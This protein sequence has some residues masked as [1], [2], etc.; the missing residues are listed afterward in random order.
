MRMRVW[1]YFYIEETQIFSK[2]SGGKML[3]CVTNNEVKSFDTVLLLVTRIC[4]FEQP[5]SYLYYLYGF[6]GWTLF[7]LV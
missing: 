5:M 4:I 2:H 1:I 7:I 6:L 3:H